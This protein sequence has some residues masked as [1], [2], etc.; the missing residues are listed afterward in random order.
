METKAANVDLIKE[1]KVELPGAPDVECCLKVEP[2]DTLVVEY[3]KM[4]ITDLSYRFIWRFLKPVATCWTNGRVSLLQTLQ[5]GMSNASPLDVYLESLRQYFLNDW[6][7][8]IANGG[9]I[10][11]EF[12][13]MTKVYKVE[14]HECQIVRKPEV[15]DAELF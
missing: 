10:P 4:P 12:E 3:V 11:P 5:M 13:W 15:E 7:M 9:S 14:L 2:G 8:N 6:R 1:V